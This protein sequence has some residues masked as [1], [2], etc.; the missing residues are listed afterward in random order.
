M[1]C[2]KLLVATIN[3]L[4]RYGSITHF[5]VKFRKATSL[6][7]HPYKF[8]RNILKLI[9]KRFK[10]KYNKAAENGNEE[11]QYNLSTYKLG[12]KN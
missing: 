9:L 4:T 1:F 8:M 2:L 7:F 5:Y 10:G 11:A 12:E 3:Y 6:F